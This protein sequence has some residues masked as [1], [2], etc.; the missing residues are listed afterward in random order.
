LENASVYEER[1]MLARANDALRECLDALASVAELDEFLGQVMAAITR[2]LGAVSST[3]AVVNREQNTL[4]VEFVYQG[5]R[6]MSPSEARY[7]ELLRVLSLD[8]KSFPTFL[9]SPIAVQRI[10]DPR[11]PVREP[12]RSYLRGLGT[13]TLLLIALTLADQPGGRLAF[14][15]TEERD[16]RPEELE[17][18][19]ALATQASLAIQL[20]RLAKTARQSAVLQ[21]RNRLAGEIHDVLAQSFAGISVQLEAAEDETPVREV[22][23]LSRIRQ[24]N[25]MAK[26]GLAEAR[27]SLFSLRSTIACESG[28]VAALQALVKRSNLAGRLRCEFRS[29]RVPEERLPARVQHE[30]LRIA[31]EAISNGVR[32]AK[33][34]VVAVALRWL[35][36]NLILQVT[37]NGSG[38]DH[39]RLEKSEGLGLVNMRAR[40]SQ[41]GGTLDIRTAAGQGTTIIVTVPISL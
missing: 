31:Q 22:R 27:R 2:Q 20:T 1:Q 16:F 26:F 32:H 13:K 25:E 33:P 3:F 35:P 18:A 23:L 36:P 15:F 5:G 7:P 17:I 41:L 10:H 29:G 12:L 21:E 28:F 24:A 37:D 39:D 8:E 38:I 14:C 40:A 9:N 6:V 11:W 30:L 4:V 34:T 19:R